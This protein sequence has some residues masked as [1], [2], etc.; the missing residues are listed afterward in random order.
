MTAWAVAPQAPLS[1]GFPTG[2][3]GRSLLQGLVPTQGS[4]QRV[5]YKAGC[6]CAGS[7]QSC[8][9]LCSPM[10][11]SPPGSSVHGI[12]Q[13]RTLEWAAIS[14]SRGTPDPGMQPASLCLPHWQADSLPLASLI[15][16]KKYRYRLTYLHA[17]V[18]A[19]EESRTSRQNM[20]GKG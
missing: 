15:L 11:G 18:Q 1:T 14:S 19:I 20:L 9:T 8:L 5:N 12:S 10:D 4:N 13:A 2:G 6:M 3:G 7:L 17:D 16:R